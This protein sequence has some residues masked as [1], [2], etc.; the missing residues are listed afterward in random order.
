MWHIYTDI[1]MI[2]Y[3]HS[4]CKLYHMTS[5]GLSVLPMT[6]M[7]VNVLH[8]WA[9]QSACNKSCHG[10]SRINGHIKKYCHVDSRIIGHMRKIL[11]RAFNDYWTYEMIGASANQVSKGVVVHYLAMGIW[12]YGASRKPKASADSTAYKM[13]KKYALKWLDW[14]KSYQEGIIQ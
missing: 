3:A 2:S 6:E 9:H 13:F 4:P 14:L 5:T 11:P 12:S 1:P 7:Y 8:T 10:D